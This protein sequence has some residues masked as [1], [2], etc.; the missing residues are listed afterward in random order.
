MECHKGVGRRRA[1]ATKES[2]ARQERHHV[3]CT[4]TDSEYKIVRNVETGYSG[5]TCDILQLSPPLAYKNN[6]HISTINNYGHSH[7]DFLS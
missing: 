4:F 7:A 2:A 5:I 3:F 1:P 6:S